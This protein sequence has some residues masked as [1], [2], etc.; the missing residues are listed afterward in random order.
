MFILGFILPIA[1]MVAAF[2][3]LPPLPY[4]EMVERAP[5]DS[6]MLD[7]EMESARPPTHMDEICY[8]SARWWRNLNRIMALVGV[9]IVAVIVT[10]AVVGAKHGW[11]HPAS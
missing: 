9:L 4:T 2:L 5:D 11:G 7:I 8:R 6:S 10:L 3:P 1:W